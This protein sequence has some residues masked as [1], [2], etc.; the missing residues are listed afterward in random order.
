[1]VTVSTVLSTVPSLTIMRLFPMDAQGDVKQYLSLIAEEYKALRDEIKQVNTNMFFIFQFGFA[2]LAGVIVAAFTQWNAKHEVVLLVFY[3][4]VP[5]ICGMTM[6]LWLGE[7]IRFKRAGDYI[8]F[9]EDKV[10]MILDD[11]KSKHGIKKKWEKLQAKI[12]EDLLLK[13]SDVDMSDPIVWEHWLRDNKGKCI[14]QG[15]LKTI[16][17]IRLSFFMLVMI[18]SLL[19]ATYYL[20][21]QPELVCGL[22]KSFLITKAKE[23]VGGVVFLLLKKFILTT[24]A[25]A[26]ILLILVG[27]GMFVLS[28]VIT[29]RIALKLNVKQKPTPRRT[30]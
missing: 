11:F 13:H 12:T 16:Y 23:V 7:A 3:V 15:H 4:I 29:L 19:I 25:E 20:L 26:L 6:I 28:L 24:K 9:I 18:F 21:N 5:A 17:F 14:T 22:K 10:G 2:A 27:L 30:D 8:Y 1:M